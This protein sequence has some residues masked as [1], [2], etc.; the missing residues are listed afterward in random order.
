M[1]KHVIFLRSLFLSILA[2]SLSISPLYAE[3]AKEEEEDKKAPVPVFDLSQTQPKWATVLDG[4]VLSQ[5]VRSSTGYIAP[6]EGKMLCSFSEEGSVVWKHS[7]KSKPDV[8]YPGIGGMMYTI[9][10]GNRLCMINPTGMEVWN[11]RL[12]FNTIEGP[13]SGRDGRVFVR[14][15]TNIA[16]YGLKGVRR[17]KIDVE[18]QNSEIP[19]VELNDGRLLAFMTKTADGK[20]VACTVSPFG[21]V[22]E[23]I[24]FSGLAKKAVACADGVLIAFTDGSIGLCSVRD[25]AT[26]S[27]WIKSSAET[28]FSSTAEIVSDV[29]DSHTAAFLSGT[30]ARL[31]IVDTRTGI[32]HSETGTSLESQSISYKT[33]TAQGLVIADKKGVECYNKDAEPVWKAIFPPKKEWN[34]IFVTDAGYIVFCQSDWTITS[35]RVMQSLTPDSLEYTE[36][37]PSQYYSLYE[38]DV[39]T[40]SPL[41]GRAIDKELYADMEKAFKKGDFRKAERH[42][43]SLLGNEMAL[44]RM[45][46]LSSSTSPM[47]TADNFFTTEYSYTKDV[48]SLAAKSGLCTFSSTIE[49]MLI[50]SNDASMLLALTRDAGEISFDPEG[51]LLNALQSVEHRA[52][53]KGNDTLLMAVC[54]ATYDICSYM[55]KPAFFQKG[56][57]ILCY[58]LQPRYSTKVRLYAKATLD[59][60]IKIKL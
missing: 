6:I 2:I 7:V 45:E 40:S 58:L 51:R 15:S 32:I 38:K 11:E 16:C 8:V 26:V 43:I 48:L 5:P 25:G 3:E 12:G 17:W 50:S 41:I 21:Y 46:L 28:G 60:I 35:Y 53:A 29:F 37:L 9:S 56:N 24:T 18:E 13:L 19:L 49:R 34:Y 22:M 57:E 59:K 42:Y 36:K 27:K 55:G 1:M 33:L 31:L 23:E 10:R 52:G 44:L 39:M 47:H 20:S 54:D 30:P 4:S 14:G